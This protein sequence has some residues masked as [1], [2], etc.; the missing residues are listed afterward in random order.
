VLT[1][2]LKNSGVIEEKGIYIS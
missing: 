2:G 1:A